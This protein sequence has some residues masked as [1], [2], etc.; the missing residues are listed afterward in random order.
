MEEEKKLHVQ[1]L[2]ESFDDKMEEN[3]T[4]E[5]DEKDAILGNVN[6]IEEL[7]S[8]I[9]LLR[10]KAATFDENIKNCDKNIKIWQSSKKMWSERAKSFMGLLE[11]LITKLNI[12]GKTVKADGVKLSTTKRTSLEVDEDWLIAQY[13]TF[14]D[15]IQTQ[16]PE[17]M[18][19]SLSIDKNKLYKHVTTDNTMLVQNPDKIHTKVTTS[20]SIK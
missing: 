10:D 7:T 14:V 18:K 1:N 4:I 17:Y 6:N 19:V 20:T 3:T 15:A 13:Q 5:Q 12:P 11:D 16:L 2:I 9:R 8:G